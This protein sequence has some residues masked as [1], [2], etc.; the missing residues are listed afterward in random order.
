MWI[1]FLNYH[2]TNHF[3]FIGSKKGMVA[4]P[5]FVLIFHPSSL[6]LTPFLFSFFL[7]KMIVWSNTTTW[8]KCADFAVVFW[9]NI[10]WLCFSSVFSAPCMED[11]AILWPP[12]TASWPRWPREAEKDIHHI[13]VFSL[14]SSSQFQQYMKSSKANTGRLN[15]T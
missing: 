11:E 6:A 2:L 7:R 15:K 10:P 13:I 5:E 8:N 3:F 14:P 12:L 4:N 9:S 1:Y